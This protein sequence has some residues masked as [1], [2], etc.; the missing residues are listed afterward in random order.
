[1]K[2]SQVFCQEELKW[3]R[4]R[5]AVVLMLLVCGLGVG[6]SLAAREHRQA[7]APPV[8]AVGDV[9]RTLVD[10]TRGAVPVPTEPPKRG[11]PHWMSLTGKQPAPVTSLPAYQMAIANPEGVRL[12]TI[13]TR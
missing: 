13:V 3:W 11:T 6:I 2:V 1:M 5:S 9:D 4:A 12:K 10:G 7:G 8:M